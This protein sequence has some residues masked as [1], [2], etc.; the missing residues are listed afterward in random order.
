V[1][2]GVT[3]QKTPFFLPREAS[4]ILKNAVFED[5]MLC[6]Y[7]YS[8]IYG[9]MYRLHFQGKKNQRSGNNVSSNQQLKQTE[10]ANSIVKSVELRLL[11]TSKIV[12]NTL[13]HFTLMMEA[14]C[15][16]EMFLS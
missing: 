3:T 12:P 1:P 11:V 5:V 10:L 14:L 2:H 7:Y 8:Q 6:C 16:T 15:S 4:T 13:I 9:E